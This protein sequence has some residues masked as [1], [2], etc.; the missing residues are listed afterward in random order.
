MSKYTFRVH[1]CVCV[2][3]YVCVRVSTGRESYDTFMGLNF[4][5][6]SGHI[7]ICSQKY[8]LIQLHI[9]SKRYKHSTF[10]SSF[11]LYFLIT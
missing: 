1:V 6:E 7:L 3:V 8:K 11:S 10:L 2:C 4:L 5:R 9:P